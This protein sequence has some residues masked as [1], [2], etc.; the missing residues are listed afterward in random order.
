MKF[1]PK[2]PFNQLP[3]LPP[4]SE[5]ETKAVLKACIAARTSL[6]EL[7]ELCDF[8]PN[9][10]VLINSIPLLEAKASS[11]IEN[12]VTTTDRLFRSA[13][14]LTEP[15]DAA[16]KEAIMYRKALYQGFLSLQQRPLNTTTAIDICQIILGIEIDIRKIPGTVLKNDTTKEIIYTP[17][18]GE[19]LLREKLSNWEQFLHGWREIDPLVRLAIQHYQFEAIHPFADGNGRTGRILNLLFLVQEQLLPLP[20]L[21]LSRSI[22]ATRTEYYQLLLKVTREGAWEEWIL[23][24]LEAVHQTALWTSSK[25]RAIR[26]LIDKVSEDIS[27]KLPSIYSREF[28]ELLFVLPYCRISD[29][30]KTGIAQRQTASVYLHQLVTKGFLKEIKAGREKIFINHQ[31]LNLLKEGD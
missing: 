31:F 9:P 10:T 6:A 24:F 2:N 3:L 8:L 16:T 5:V 23:Y 7:K 4:D 27:E 19:K 1:D 14:E 17:P 28:V 11:E 13:Y 12:I 22:L 21:Y 20:I 26:E 30:V 18:V 15:T 25:I 29:L